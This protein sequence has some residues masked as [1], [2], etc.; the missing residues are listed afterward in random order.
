VVLQLG[1]WDGGLT[2]PHC[3]ISNLLRNVVESLGSGRILCLVPAELIR[4]G[5]ETLLS[6]IHKL[7]KMICNKEGL[8]HQWKE[9]IVDPIHKNGDK[10]N[11]SNYRG[12][13][14]LSTSHKILSNI[15][16]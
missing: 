1:G 9:S 10:T 8:P 15:L 5:G 14:L 7:I 11:C 2:T 4:A 16:L 12:I 6:E 13:S 3:K